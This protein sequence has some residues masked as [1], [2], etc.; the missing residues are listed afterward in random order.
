MAQKSYR[1]TC[2]ITNTYRHKLTKITLER[3]R[4][5]KKKNIGQI[6]LRLVE[7]SMYF[8]Y[9]RTIEL[10]HQKQNI[11]KDSIPAR[12]KSELVS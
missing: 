4:K 8:G 7:V 6:D 9:L 11:M 2:S 5:C 12:K 10:E 3:S 1:S